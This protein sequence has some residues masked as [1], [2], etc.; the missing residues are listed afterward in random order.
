MVHDAKRLARVAILSA[1][2][3]L[4]PSSAKRM[5]DRV[6]EQERRDASFHTFEGNATR[7]TPNEEETL[8]VL[9]DVVS[10][11]GTGMGVAGLTGNG[12][13]VFKMAV[14]PASAGAAMSVASAGVNVISVGLT[15]Y[16]LATRYEK[17]QYC[18]IARKG[19]AIVLGV[20][21]TGLAI[22]SIFTAGVAAGVVAG[23]GAAVTATGLLNSNFD[24][25]CGEVEKLISECMQDNGFRTVLANCEQAVLHK[26]LS[27]V[28]KAMLPDGQ[29]KDRSFYEKGKAAAKLL[30]QVHFKS[31]VLWPSAMHPIDNT[32]WDTRSSWSGAMRPANDTFWDQSI[33]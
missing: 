4:H 26:I 24:A 11:V 2:L 1:W 14:L 25:F 31:T 27:T 3:S 16:E 23:I 5:V 13:D 20:L 29:Y 21:G 19:T 9:E 30:A 17:T 8:I 32:F 33:E 18:Q 15:S 7:F 28:S 12:L 22:S 10:Q 6:G